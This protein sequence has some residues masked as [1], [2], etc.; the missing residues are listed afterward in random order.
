MLGLAFVCLVIPSTTILSSSY[1]QPSMGTVAVPHNFVPMNY[2]SVSMNIILKHVDRCVNRFRSQIKYF[3][4]ILA[5][6][7]IHRNKI[8]QFCLSLKPNFSV[9]IPIRNIPLALWTKLQSRRDF[10]FYANAPAKK[11]TPSISFP[12][13]QKVEK[14]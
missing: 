1:I 9:I 4:A 12:N 5:I 6:P 3:S 7:R 14:C 8:G 2:Y 13:V 10:E 11:R